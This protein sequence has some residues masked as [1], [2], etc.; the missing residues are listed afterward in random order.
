[1]PDIV[2]SPQ[3]REY[4]EASG[5]PRVVCESRRELQLLDLNRR[6]QQV[7]V[8]G[9]AERIEVQHAKGKLTARER[10][11]ALLDPGSFQE[12]GQLVSHQGQGK[13]AA[14]GEGVITGHGTIA[15]R[16]A[17][18]YSQDFTVLGGTLGEGHAA[19][20][21]R[22]MDMAMK[23]GAPVIGMND[24]GG[25]RI[26]EGVQ[27]L[28]GYADIFLRNTLASGVIPQLS[29]M[30]GPCAGGAAYSPAITDFIF[31]AEKTS[32]MFVTGPNVLR[33]VTHEEVTSE[34]LGGAAIHAEKSGVVHFTA[35][36]EL[37]VLAQA[38]ALLEFLPQNNQEKP[39]L[40]ASNDPSH[41]KVPELDTLVPEDPMKPYDMRD[42][43]R[44]V[45]DHGYFFEVA[46][47]YA[48]NLITGFI[49]LDGESIGVVAN[50]P[51]HL[52]GC[53]DMDGSIKGARFVR[54]CDCYNIPLLVFE[55]VPGFLPGVNQEHGGII[56]HGAKLLYAFC[57]ATVPRVTVI[58]RKAY[59]GAYVVMNS[60]H[61]RGDLSFAWPSAELAVMGA[62]GAVEIIYKKEIAAAAD[63]HS[64]AASKE[65]EYARQFANPYQAAERGY[66]DEVIEPRMTRSRLAAAFRLLSTKR[67]R[68][69]VRKHGNIPL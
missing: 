6:R 39:P 17:F 51:K 45:A 16:I 27:S 52:A 15:G 50:Q 55:D 29:L 56:R 46:P 53:L 10:I 68:N 30:L 44:S 9:G 36:H 25:A 43:I 38:R 4:V 20:I 19:K 37:S 59:G 66:I 13:A 35:P 7:L 61:I 67:D 41:R 2:E 18:V 22:M 54:T 11:E 31:M 34:A 8:G 1:M 58:T 64:M 48:P 65:A 63:P 40:R 33:T 12:L 23:V 26:Q 14:P 47:R 28:A 21:C 3:V 62:K 32:Y 60:R 24:S 69:P 49:H 5:V 42:A 57:E